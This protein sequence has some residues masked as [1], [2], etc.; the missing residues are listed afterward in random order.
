MILIVDCG[1]VKTPEIL[2]IVEKFGFQGEIVAL[3]KI[4]DSNKS[5][6]KV[7]IS[8]APILLS[9]IEDTSEYIK[10]AQFLLDL[11]IPILGICFGHQIIGM[12][13]G[14][15]VFMGKEDRAGQNINSSKEDW[16]TKGLNEVFEMQEDHCEYIDLPAEFELLASSNIT[17]VE[18]MKHQ[19]KAIYGCQFHPEVSGEVGSRFIQNFLSI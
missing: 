17:Q 15:S 12:A 11:K 5:W 16:I 10:K 19:S 2:K 13:Y 14:A 4:K 8:G 1:S 9:Q 3:E 7:I 18:L 6:E